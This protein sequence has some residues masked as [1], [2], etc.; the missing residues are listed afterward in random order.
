VNEQDIEHVKRTEHL[1]VLVNIA[2]RV[3][4]QRALALLPILTS[5]GFAVWAMLAESWLKLAGAALVGVLV[6]AVVK[7]L[8]GGSNEP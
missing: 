3:L 1:A 4:T 7:A 8:Q 6:P 5:I 2:M